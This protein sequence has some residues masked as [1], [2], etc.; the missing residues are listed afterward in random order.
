MSMLK[1]GGRWECQLHIFMIKD[2]DQIYPI[3]QENYTKMKL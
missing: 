3:T 1:E 2:E